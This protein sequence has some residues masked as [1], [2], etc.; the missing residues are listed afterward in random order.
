MKYYVLQGV[1]IQRDHDEPGGETE[2]DAGGWD[3]EALT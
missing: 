3:G 1:W 2:Q